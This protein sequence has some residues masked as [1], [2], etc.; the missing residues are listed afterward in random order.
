MW[1]S[2]FYE[3]EYGLLRGRHPT[4]NDIAQILLPETLRPGV[5][6]LAHYSKLSGR[7]GQTQTYHHVRSTYYWTQMAADIY[8]T[9]R[10]SNASAKNRVKLRKHAHPL[11]FF[12]AQRA[13]E[14]HSIDI[15][16][17]LTKTKKGHRFLIVVTDCFT[18]LTQVIPLRRIDAYTVF[19]AV[20]EACIFKCGPPKT[21][22]PDNCKQFAANF[23]QAVCSLL[24]LSNIFTSTHH[25]QTNVQVERYN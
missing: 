23:F 7:P 4:I 14:C 20:V 11:R 25:P 13:P 22:I 2:A 1:D 15:H 12:P 6:D 19:V 9:F 21:L 8:R 3:D 5:L 16:E 10:T 24:G 18:K 17:S